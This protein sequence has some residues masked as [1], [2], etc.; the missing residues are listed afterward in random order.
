M[1]QPRLWGAEWMETLPSSHH[2]AMLPVNP[3]HHKAFEAEVD[4]TLNHLCNLCTLRQNLHLF[5]MTPLKPTLQWPMPADGPFSY[6]EKPTN[7]QSK[8]MHDLQLFM[9]FP[10]ITIY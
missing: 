4:L 9:Q 3:G 7:T 5:V 8:A 1:W 6:V 10:F 2:T